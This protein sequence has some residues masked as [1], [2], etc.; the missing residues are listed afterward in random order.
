MSEHEA[1][2]KTADMSE[3]MQ[4]DAVDCATQALEKYD[5]EKVWQYTEVTC[6]D[7]WLVSWL[8]CWL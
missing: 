1:I 2:N 8:F 5:N 4:Q 7:D 6:L 3:K